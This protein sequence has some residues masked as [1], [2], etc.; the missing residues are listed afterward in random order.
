VNIPPT[1]FSRYLRAVAVELVRHPEWRPGQT[2]WNIASGPEFGGFKPLHL[3][4]G[5]DVDPFHFDHR[6]PAF[7][8]V[9]KRH[10]SD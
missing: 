8:D 4:S 5:C 7:L 10:W 1:R 3:V 2:Y 6:V 9:L